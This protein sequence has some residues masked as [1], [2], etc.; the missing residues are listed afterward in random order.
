MDASRFDSVSKFFANRRLSRRDAM[1]KGSSVLAATGLA[2]AGLARSANAQDATPVPDEGAAPAGPS[3]RDPEMLFVQ[4]FQAGAI[5]AKEG[6][7]GRYTLT[8]ES[9]IDQTI[10]FSDRPDRIV[11]A[12]PTP[13]LLDMLGFS[14]DDPPNAA[15]VVETAPGETDVAVVELFAPVYDEASKGLTYEIEVLKNW[16]REL[17]MEFSEYP[18]DLASLEPSF[19]AAHLFIDGIADCPDGTMY[20]SIDGNTIGEIANADHDGF[21]QSWSVPRMCLPCD[22]WKTNDVV[23]YWKGV[24]NERFN[25]CQGRCEVSGWCSSGSPQVCTHGPGRS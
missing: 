3:P 4:T 16:R 17:D 6:A 22:P 10:Y 24:C 14:D 11:G 20:C 21:C 5:V 18:T 13:E 9:G 8:L 19:G 15:L 25:D 12:M 7:E 2:A 23:S 1:I